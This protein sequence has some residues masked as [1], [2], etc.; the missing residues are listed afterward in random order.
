[1]GSKKKLL[2]KSRL[3]VIADNARA[4]ER[5]GGRAV[6]MIQLRD[7]AS[8]KEEVLSRAQEFKKL[9]ASN[10]TIFIVN[11]YIDIAMIAGSDGV[12]LGQGDT[13]LNIARRL[14]G[15]SKIIGKSCH[16]LNQALNAQ[17]EGADYIG[18]GPVFKTP[19]KP[20]RKAV[21]LAL[22]KKVKDAV[23]I[24]VFAIGGIN[25]ENLSQV[26]SAGVKRIAV[27]RGVLNAKYPAIAAKSLSRALRAR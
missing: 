16:T 5:L 20:G 4:I 27:S 26:L 17:N 9:F 19:T 1:M 24:P 2:Q 23:K 3:Y 25:E 8:K 13:P 18:V 15:K 21:G 7:K 10:G 14:L 6:D 11:D 12:H 22:L